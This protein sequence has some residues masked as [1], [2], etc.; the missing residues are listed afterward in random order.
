MNDEPLGKMSDG[1][2][3]DRLQADDDPLTLPRGAVIAFQQSGGLRFSTRSLV[4][5]RDGRVIRQR[6]GKLE[7]K[8]DVQHITLEEVANLQETIA[9]SGLEKLSGSIGQPSPDGYAYELIAR[10][11]RKSRAFEFFDG[12]IPVE[13][14]PLLKRLKQLFS[15]QK[16]SPV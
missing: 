8:G 7:A 14:K 12:S 3:D 9:H 5:Y 2:R 13:V 4:V 1:P 15:E 10:V 16:T 6:Q 11:G